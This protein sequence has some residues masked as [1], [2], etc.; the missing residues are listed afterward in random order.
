MWAM[1]L[2][3]DVSV[4]RRRLRKD[5]RERVRRKHGLPKVIR[6]NQRSQF[7]EE[8]DV[9]VY[10]KRHRIEDLG[11]ATHR[12]SELGSGPIK[13]TIQER[14]QK[15]RP[16]SFEPACHSALRYAPLGSGRKRGNRSTL[17]A[18][19]AE[20]ATRRFTQSQMHLQRFIFVK[21]AHALTF[22]REPSRGSTTQGGLNS[23]ESL[24]S[25]SRVLITA[26]T[27]AL[28]YLLLTSV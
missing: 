9:W 26:P 8:L 28:P 21:P 4:D 20:D 18:A 24:I 22:T 27:F 6:V 16:S 13:S 3:D 19:R 23:R 2:P 5:R 15:Q 17:L 1:S 12:F 11:S 7:L 14:G 25:A 10:L